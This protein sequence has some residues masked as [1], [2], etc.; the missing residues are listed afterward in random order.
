[1]LSVSFTRRK[2]KPYIPRL[3]HALLDGDDDHRL[4]FCEEFL[5]KLHEEDTMLDNIGWSDETCFKLNGIINRHNCVYWAA[6]NPRVTVEKEVN[7][8]GVTVWA[9][10]SPLGHNQSYFAL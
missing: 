3:L 2:W 10:I 7:L 8:P 4:Q 9:A 6:N 1:M 5:A